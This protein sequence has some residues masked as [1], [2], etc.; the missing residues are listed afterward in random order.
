MATDSGPGFWQQLKAIPMSVKIMVFVVIFVL[1]IILTSITGY[2]GLFTWWNSNN[3]KKYSKNFSLL[4]F[5]MSYQNILLFYIF[6]LSGNIFSQ[7]SL[8]SINEQK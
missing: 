2:T 6:S 8:E 4:T 1:Y 3:G 5:V 7:L